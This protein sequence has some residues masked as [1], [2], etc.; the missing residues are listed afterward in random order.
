MPQM[1]PS[2]FTENLA[3]RATSAAVS[4]HTRPD[5]RAILSKTPQT[6][7]R[8]AACVHPSSWLKVLSFMGD[9]LFA[10]KLQ[11]RSVF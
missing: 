4:T 2:L 8:A 5:S 1:W 9:Y 10:S 6:R 7:C 11:R 3:R